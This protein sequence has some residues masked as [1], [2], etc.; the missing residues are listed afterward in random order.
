MSSKI[1]LPRSDESIARIRATLEK[2]LGAEHPLP[3]F[4]GLPRATRDAA[5]RFWSQRAWSE[6]CALPVV[7]Q[8]S[9]KLAAEGAPLDEL[10]SVAGILQ[11][12]ALHTALSARAAD[13]FG[14]Y[15]EDIP[16]YLL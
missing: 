5:R 8:I 14:G 15:V 9:L 11:D 2:R 12:E 16:D 6:Y 10:A 7:S 1:A 4:G 3:S 13:A